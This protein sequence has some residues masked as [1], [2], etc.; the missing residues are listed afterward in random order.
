MTLPF[1]N[2]PFGNGF[3]GTGNWGRRVL[4]LNV[5]T[6][7]RDLDVDG[8][9]EGLLT[10][11]GNALEVEREKIKNLPL[12][13]EPYLAR[14]TEGEGEWFFAVAAEDYEDDNYGSVVRLIGEADENNFPVLP[15]PTPSDAQLAEWYPWYPYSSAKIISTN[16]TLKW[17]DV[18]YDVVNVRLRNFDPHTVDSTTN[19]YQAGVSLGNEV[20]L[21]GGERPPY[22]VEGESIGTG[23]GTNSPDI[24]FVNAPFWLQQNDTSGAI[25]PAPTPPAANS[26]TIEDA[27]V[28]VVVDS[29]TFG[30][31]ALYDIPD[32]LSGTYTGNLYP[33][34]VGTPGYIDPSGGSWGLVCYRSSEI[35]LN[36]TADTVVLGSDITCDYK[37]YAYTFQFFPPRM[38]DFLAKDFGF[39][40]DSNDPESI[41]RSTIANITKYFGMK[42]IP[43]S[44]RIR[45]E[46]SAFDV[47]ASGLYATNDASFIAYL[48][49]VVPDH[50]WSYASSTSSYTDIEPRFIRFDDIS[51]D[52]ELWDY[53]DVVAAD[54]FVTLMDN[55]LI[56][57]DNS[58][59]EWSVGKAY[60]VDVWQGYQ[61]MFRGVPSGSPDVTS[62]PAWVTT[63][64]QLTVPELLSYSLASGWKVTVRMMERQHEVYN[65]RRGVFGLVEYNQ[66]TA[67]PPTYDTPVWWIDAEESWTTGGAIPAGYGEA[68]YIIG[69]GAGGTAPTVGVV[70]ATGTK[71]GMRYY[72]ELLGGDCNY[73]K[74]YRMRVKIADNS[75]TLI[76]YEVDEIEPAVARLI[77]KVENTLVPIHARVYYVRTY[78][79][80]LDLTATSTAQ[81]QF[82]NSE[83]EDILGFQLDRIELKMEWT[84]DLS[85]AND[86]SLVAKDGDSSVIMAVDGSPSPDPPL[87]GRLTDGLNNTDWRIAND[88]VR[89]I[90]GIDVRSLLGNEKTVTLEADMGANTGCRVRA[91]LEVTRSKV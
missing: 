59:D 34:S 5:P 18:E 16:W 17:G 69:T 52:E 74:S 26:W 42:A 84:G 60:C 56:F 90:I 4:W 31:T 47:T 24:E 87:A 72:P 29:A 12:Q 71:V 1:G 80:V 88:G 91:T 55:A 81:Y 23:D 67:V 43:D 38:L 45:G 57:D 77:S 10:S 78:E 58:N 32:G 39:E 36:L 64:A 44:Y 7:H 65:F 2:G 28:K 89:D 13:R 66:S 3:F 62:V 19:L 61:G 22:I 20:W 75:D 6:L 50:V 9:L 37:V 79:V 63:T 48:E 83:F 46:I 14:G 85:G 70:G 30:L 21:T 49:S 68:V 33:E 73:C 11:W 35:S 51:A 86:V 25:I 15:T 41:Q 53:A 76:N 40:N 54:K 27:K 8:Q 82:V